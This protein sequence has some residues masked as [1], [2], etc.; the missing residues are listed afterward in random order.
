MDKH[1]TCSPGMVHGTILKVDQERTPINTP[2]KRK[3][4][5]DT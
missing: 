3:T 4:Y 1:L 2:E 5:D